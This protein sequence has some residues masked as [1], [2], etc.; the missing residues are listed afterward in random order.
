MTPPDK[1]LSG[2]TTVTDYHEAKR[3]LL[4]N[5]VKRG[6]IRLSEIRTA[7]PEVH[8]SAAELEL[9]LYSLEAL[10]VEVLSDE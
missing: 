8:L 3:E 1:T 5:A 6:T 4:R 2:D 10:D 7:L 9:L